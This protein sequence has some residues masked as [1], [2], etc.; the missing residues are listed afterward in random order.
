MEADLE[1]EDK[2]PNLY[3]RYLDDTITEMPDVHEAKAFL[4]TLYPSIIFNN[5]YR[6]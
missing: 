1:K 5:N 4:T 2:L 6:K 3:I